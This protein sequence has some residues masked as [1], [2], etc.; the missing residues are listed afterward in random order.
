MKNKHVFPLIVTL[1][2]LFAGVGR[3]A[4][5]GPMPSSRTPKDPQPSGQQ[6]GFSARVA[7]EGSSSSDGQVFDLNTSTGYTFNKFFGLDLG[8]PFYFAHASTPSSGSGPAPRTSSSGDIG[9]LYM[10]AHLSLD[11]PVAPYRTTFTVT[12]PTGDVNKGRSTGRFT[13]DWDNRVEHEFLDRVTPYIDAGLAN[14]VSD[15][16]FF[17]RPFI[18]LGKLAHFEAG[19]DVKLW[20]SLTFTA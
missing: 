18:T 12:A 15:T 20:K 14:S 17:K 1:L 16:R 5:Q 9:N 11:N 4:A 19:A 8:M 10:D 6:S 13:Y 3:L 2:F 7:F